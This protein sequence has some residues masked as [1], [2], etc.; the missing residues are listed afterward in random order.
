MGGIHAS[1][2]PDEAR[3]HV[4]ALVKG[5]AEIIWPTV[6]ADAHAAPCGL[7]MREPSPIWNPPRRR[8]TIC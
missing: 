3:E 5:E 8:A 7:F 1:M 4:D 2:C 6:L